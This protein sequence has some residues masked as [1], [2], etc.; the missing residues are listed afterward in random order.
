VFIKLVWSSE[1]MD[2]MI[3]VREEKL[4]KLHF[5]PGRALVSTTTDVG[6]LWHRNMAHLHFGALG[7]LRQAVTELP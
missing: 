2:K 4:Y 3:G 7:N 5:H 1:K 6:E